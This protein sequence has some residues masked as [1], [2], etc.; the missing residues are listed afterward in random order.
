MAILHDKVN[1]AKA[2]NVEVFHWRTRRAGNHDF[3]KGAAKKFVLGPHG[4]VRSRRAAAELATAASES[5]VDQHDGATENR[6]RNNCG[7]RWS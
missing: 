6:T 5:S 4:M 1:I 2:V 7:S 3:D